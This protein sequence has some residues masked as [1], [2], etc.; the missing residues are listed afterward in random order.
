M[1]K[2]QIFLHTISIEDI[3]TSQY[4]LWILFSS[5]FLLQTNWYFPT[6]LQAHFLYFC[7]VFARQ[8]HI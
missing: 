2:G 3:Q 4:L 6:V 1:T 8:C 7:Y 5:N